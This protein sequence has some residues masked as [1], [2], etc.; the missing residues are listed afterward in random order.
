MEL[1]TSPDFDELARALRSLNAGLGAADLHGSLC[2]YLCAGGQ[3]EERFL[4]AMSLRELL[5]T[6]ADAQ[7]RAAVARLFRR[8]S[9]DLDDVEFAFEPLLPDSER[10]LAERTGALLQWC[11]GFVGGLGLGGFADEQRLSADGR[12]V[13]RDLLEIARSNVSHDSDEEVD[14]TALAELV[15]FA[16]VGAL[17]LR[18]D[19]R[20]DAV[21]AR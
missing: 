5:G 11:Q 17:L 19:L 6:D 7:A 21:A 8:S 14:E 4:E 15:E 12:E 9:S 1:E 16:R 20:S 13:L 18:E 3:G 10:P 2:G